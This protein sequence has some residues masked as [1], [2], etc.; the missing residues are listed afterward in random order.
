MAALLPDSILAGSTRTK[1][2]AGKPTCKL[3]GIEPYA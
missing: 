3:W 2:Q 1:K